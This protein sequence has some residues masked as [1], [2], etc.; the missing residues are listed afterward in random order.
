MNKPNAVDVKETASGPA[1]TS[2]SNL[3]ANA[4]Q[5]ARF[6]RGFDPG[7]IVEGG[8]GQ[9]GASQSITSKITNKAK[10]VFYNQPTEGVD[11]A[12][13]RQKVI[14][15]GFDPKAAG[16]D[17]LV[18]S[19]VVPETAGS[20]KIL[21]T[22]V[23]A[24]TGAAALGLTD[25][26]PMKELPDPYDEESPS[27]RRLRENRFK[28]RTGVPRFSPLERTLENIMVPA[29][30]YS[31]RGGVMSLAKGGNAQEFPRR[32]GYISGPGTETSDSIP[33]ML[34]DGEF[35]MNARAVRGAGGGS[36]EKGVRRMY[37]M[38]RAFEGGAAA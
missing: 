18:L 5:Q 9:G 34:S 19:Q 13:A 12:A 38:M 25:E 35:V 2:G 11:L 8:K 7:S 36:R 3:S 31:A 24:L 27:E 6:D 37:D 4:A 33:A 21:P 32:T 30:Q 26:I 1:S 22:A 14:G 29:T 15:A 28:F 20:L 17:K 10:D 23:A 16:F